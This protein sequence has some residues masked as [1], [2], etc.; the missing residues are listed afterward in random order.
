MSTLRFRRNL[1]A[2]GRERVLTV[3]SRGNNV[4]AVPLYILPPLFACFFLFPGAEPSRTFGDIWPA[5]RRAWGVSV[6][7]SSVRASS[8]RERKAA[9]LAAATHFTL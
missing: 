6:A 8:R 4:P 2:M 1:T 7:K 5:W 3:D 9:P